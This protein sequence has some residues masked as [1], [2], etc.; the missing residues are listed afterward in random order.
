MPNY[1]QYTREQLLEELK[2]LKDR[3]KQARI[4][5]SKADINKDIVTI[6]RILNRM[7]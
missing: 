1:Y 2:V 7:G 3:K 6:V 4:Q 5:A